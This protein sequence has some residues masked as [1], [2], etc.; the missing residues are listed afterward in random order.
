MVV[1]VLGRMAGVKTSDYT[2]TSFS[3]VKAGSWYAPYVQWASKQ[4]P[5]QGL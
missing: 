1:T 2:G 5:R 4:G 3:D